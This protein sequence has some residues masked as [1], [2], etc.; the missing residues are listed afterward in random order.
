LLDR[1]VTAVDAARSAGVPVIFV[2][3]AF[4]DGYPEVAASN[5]SFGALATMGGFGE[6]DAATQLHPRVAPL[7]GE[8][9]VTKRRTSAFAGSDLAEVLRG[10]RIDT[11]VLTGIATSGVVL[12]TL[13]QAADLDYGLVVL[14]D[15]CGDAD[16]E[17]HRVLTTKVFPRQAE[18]STVDEWVA[19]LKGE[20]SRR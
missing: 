19:G 17:V 3:V 13:R 1:L 14:A 11:L 7:P 2:R 16:P 5:R 8:V 12:S 6:S 9:V 18:V 10:G 4:R 20:F 15:A